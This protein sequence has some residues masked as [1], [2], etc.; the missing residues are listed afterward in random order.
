VGLLVAILQFLSLL[1][2]GRGVAKQQKQDEASQNNPLGRILSVYNA[3]LAQDVETLSLKLDE[4]ILRETPRL[5][6][7][8]ITLAI[9]AAIAPMLG[10]LGTVSGMIETFQAITLFGTG[11]PKLMSGGIS[12]AL[13]TTELGLAVAI[14]LLLIHSGLSSKSNRLIQI[15][16]EESAAIVARNAE[17]QHGQSD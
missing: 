14:P 10:L 9:L 16:D 7:G 2:A 15:L 6:R 13:V 11:D 17:K 12:Q 1:R 5:E 8:L 4:A 3:K